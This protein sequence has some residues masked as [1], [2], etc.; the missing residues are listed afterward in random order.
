MRLYVL[1]HGG[2]T[3]GDH[4]RADYY[5][6]YMGKYVNNLLVTILVSIVTIVSYLLKLR[7]ME[8]HCL[9]ILL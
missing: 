8:S 7:L 6:M 4:I 2:R 1:G 3:L 9:P 5:I